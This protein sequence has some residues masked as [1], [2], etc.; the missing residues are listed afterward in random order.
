MHMHTL[1]YTHTLCTYG[2]VTHEI[3]TRFLET[4]TW[5]GNLKRAIRDFVKWCWVSFERSCTSMGTPHK[6]P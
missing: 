1:N 2:R 5:N 3:Y 6:Q 4:A